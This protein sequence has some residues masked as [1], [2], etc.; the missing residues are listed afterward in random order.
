M[1]YSPICPAQRW[2]SARRRRAPDRRLHPPGPPAHRVDDLGMHRRIT[3]RRRRSA[4]RTARHHPPERVR[5]P[6]LLRRPANRTTRGHRRA[7]R[8]RRRRLRGHRPCP[9]PR[10]AD[11]RTRSSAVHSACHRVRSSAAI[12][13]RLPVEGAKTDLRHGGC[14]PRRLMACDG[15]HL[16][17]SAIAPSPNVDGKRRG[18]S[19]SCHKR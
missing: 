8:D 2:S 12:R 6:C 9:H 16:I 19:T 13:R 1:R 7:N 18:C 10:R 3:A 4:Q 11:R 14:G 17:P 5:R 15:R